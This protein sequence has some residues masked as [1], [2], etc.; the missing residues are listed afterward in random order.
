MAGPIFALVLLAASGGALTADEAKAHI[1]QTATVE[2]KVSVHRTFD[3]ETY[4]YVGGSGP[5]APFSAYVS[6]WNQV[7]FQDVDK[8]DGKNVQITG[9]ISTFRD[10][11][12]IFLTDSG[13]LTEKPEPQPAPPAPQ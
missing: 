5:S 9:Q 1:G 2:G 4:I 7:Q 8:L 13:Q 6:R 12:E 3:G 10:K 11:P